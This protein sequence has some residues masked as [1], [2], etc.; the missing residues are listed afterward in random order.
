MQGKESRKMSGRRTRLACCLILTCLILLSHNLLAGSPGARSFFVA[1]VGHGTDGIG[2]QFSTEINFI[3]LSTT[4]SEVVIRTFSDEGD[5]LRLIE[6][7]LPNTAPE[8]V[9][10]LTV[11]IPG[12]GTARTRS[13]NPNPG[14]ALDIGWAQISTAQAVGPKVVFRIVNPADQLVTAADIRVIPIVTAASLFGHQQNT[15]GT[16]IALLNP[17]GNPPARISLEAIGN[18]GNSILTSFIDL[19]PGEKT[20]RFLFQYMPSLGNFDGSIEIRSRNMTDPDSN[21]R[22]PIAILPLNQQGLILTTQNP[23]PP[24]QRP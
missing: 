2:N 4:T 3:N 24:R 7:N 20:A 1:Q 9:A 22:P 23:F 11:Q 13:L 12:T 17:F 10:E 15:S 19:L 16:A 14:T 6:Q 8:S 5:P 21:D 18:D